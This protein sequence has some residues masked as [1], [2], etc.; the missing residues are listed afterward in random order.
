M[1]SSCVSKV[2]AI[3]ECGLDYDRL[4]FCPPEIQKKYVLYFLV[5]YCLLLECF[6]FS[7]NQVIHYVVAN[8]GILRSSLNW[9]TPLS[10]PCFC[11]CAQLLKI[12]VKL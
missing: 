5:L 12:S 10:C 7:L 2:V 11:I 4:Q 9:H 8:L 1:F 6:Y 3:G